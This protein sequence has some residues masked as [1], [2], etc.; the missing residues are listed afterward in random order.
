MPDRSGLPSAVRGM[1]ATASAAASRSSDGLARITASIIAVARKT[2]RVMAHLAD[3]TRS[4]LSE[5]AV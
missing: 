2:A 1:S 4:G 5:A 3:D